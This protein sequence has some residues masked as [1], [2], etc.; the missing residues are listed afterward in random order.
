MF[1][2][3]SQNLI[4]SLLMAVLLIPSLC[5]ADY[6][7]HE[8]AIALIDDLVK[9]HEFD[10]ATLTAIFAGAE[11]K[12][13]ILEAI[14]RPA[15]K[16]LEWFEYRRI[17]LTKDRIDKGLAFIQEHLVTLQRAE[18]EF[19]VPKEMIASIIGV[20]TRYGKHKGSHKVLDALS[21][22]GFDYPPR[23]SFFSSEL[24]HA[25]LLAKEQGFDIREMTGSYAGAMGYGQFIPSSYRHYAIDFDGDKI[26]DILNN[27][28]DAIGSVANYFSMHKWIRGKPIAYLLSEKDLGKNYKNFSAKSLKPTNSIAEI[29]KSGVLVP[30]KLASDDVAK[31]QSFVLESGEE[32]WL[33]LNNFYVI[34]RYN[35]SHLYAMAVY[36]LAQELGLPK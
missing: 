10:R 34:T 31:I 13:S 26:V 23:A 19:G 17:F 35:H 24:K 2:R 6:S 30:I 21:T 28:V 3:K 36:Q 9:D 11:R 22:L 33:T 16:R 25:F 4:P 8:K 14:A 1:R 15:E 5:I 18:N 20:E 7:T 32:N 27:P 29:R 12:E